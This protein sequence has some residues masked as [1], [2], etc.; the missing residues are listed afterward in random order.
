MNSL[1]DAFIS[2][3]RADSRDFAKY[4]ND[5]L[6]EAGY[7]IWYDFEDI[8]FGVDYQKQI[9]DGIEKADN[10]L[11]IISPHSVNSPYCGLE[12]ELA[13]T[14]NKRIIPLL[15]VEQISRK[16]WQQRN[17]NGTD[18]QWAD[19]QA[20]GKHSSFPNM[21]PEI[22]KINWVYFREGLDDF[23]TSFAGLLELLERHKAYV[24]QHTVL[25]DRALTWERNQ[26]QTRY[27]LI[28]S[29][30]EQA[31]VW[32]ATRFTESQPPCL[33]IDLQC[34]FITE[35]IK[36]ANNLMTQV[37]LCHAEEDR[38]SAEQIRR[39]LLRQG[40]TVWNYRTDIQI[41]QDYHSAIAQGIE[42]ADNVLLMLSPHSTQ[43]AYCQR[44]LEQALAFNKRIIPILAAPIDPE[45][46][47]DNLRSLQ[48]IDLTDN[49]VA[50]D[51]L[52]DESQ[53]LK[54]LNT[55]AAYYTE[56]KT[57]LTQ[58][59]KWQ[60]Q[61]QNPTM[62]LRGY[63]LRRAENWLKVARTHRHLPTELHET[64]IAESLKQPPDPSLDVF[65]SYSRVDSD[66]SRRLNETLQIQGKRTWFDQESIAS[67]TDFQQEI[68][69]GIESSDVFL[70]VL[71][72]QSISSPYCA[73]EVEYAYG[74]NKRIVT[75]LHRPIDT[76]DLHPVLAKLQWIDFR[77]HDGD[78]QVNFQ[79]LLRTL[80]TNREHLET[81]TRLLLR[82][83]EW[84]RRGRDESLLLRGQDLEVA[85]NW[86]ET[87]AEID[88]RP[89]GLQ[90]EYIRAGRARQT[91]QE[92]AEKKLRRGAFIGAVAAAAGVLVAV[93]SG[94]FAW[95]Q[96]QQARASIQDADERIAEADTRVNEANIRVDE[97]KEQ[98]KAANQQTEQ[99]NQQTQQAKQ[100]QQAAVD[101]AQQAAQAQTQAETHA[102]EADGKAQS[103]AA[104]QRQA[105]AKAQ[106]ADEKAQDAEGR[107]R[108]ADVRA[109]EADAKTAAA[110]VAQRLAQTGTRL[111]QAGNAAFNRLRF[112]T[113]GALL[114]ALKAGKELSQIASDVSLT[115]IS[116][117][118]AVSPLLVLQQIK[119]EM[120]GN[121]LF[122]HTESVLSASFGPDG[123]QV[124]TVSRDGTARVWDLASG[125]T[126]VLEG[127][128]S[129]VY[130]T[131]FS[132][133]GTQVVTVSAAGSVRVWDLASG[134]F[135]VLEGHESGVNNASFNH[136]GTQVVTASGDG[137][138]RVWDL[139]SGE[140]QVL[141]GHESWVYS[142]SFNPDGTQVVTA[143]GDGTARVWDL[144]SGETQ[145]L[146]GHESGANNASFSSDGTQVLTVSGD[147][148][149]R[150]WDL[151]SGETQVLEG[152]ETGANNASFNPDGTQVVTA[153]G[154]GTARV[155]DLASGETQ[156][157]EGR[158]SGVNSASFSPDGTQV[159]TVS[160][161][162]SA[163]V[164]DLASGESQVLEG[165]K[166]QV[167]SASFS[168]DGTQVVTA[169]EDGTARVWKVA[170]DTSWV[171]NSLENLS[172]SFSPDGTQIVTV[173]LNET[174]QVWNL[175]TGETQVLEGYEGWVSSASFSPNGIQ[176]VTTLGDGTAQVWDLAS[177]RFQ[178]LEGHESG[179]LITSLSS[180]GSHVVTTLGDGTAQV[181]DL[182]S[183]E[184]QVLKGHEGWVLGISFSPNVTQVV[185]VLEGGT[186]QVW[187][188]ASGETQVLK[189]HEGEVNSV[190]FS[191]DETQVVTVSADGTARV[192]NLASGESQVLEGHKDQVNS[193][194][195]SPDGTQVVTASDDFTVRLWDLKS[196]SFTLL[197]GHADTVRSASF[198]TA[199]D[200]IVTAATDGTMRVWDLRGRQLAI[201]E[202]EAGAL[203]PNGQQVVTVVDGRVQVHDIE[204]L[205]ELIDW[206][207]KWLHN[208]L[209]YGQATDSDRALCNLPPRNSDAANSTPSESS[210]LSRALNQ[211]RKVWRYFG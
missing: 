87:Y 39:S 111:E 123:T 100:A 57:W 21:H 96:Q 8:P 179:V 117:Y 89:T 156:V 60:R 136:N 146:K 16:T 32:L 88:P 59:L 118:P 72:P 137:T 143:S 165:H 37:F 78:F 197:E 181:W 104:A 85:E 112:D 1:Q 98:A 202:G 49:A 203:S 76:V 177:G 46:I 116:D 152:H 83:G 207:C 51:Y 29:D 133:D 86:L 66:F 125:E 155:W 94:W 23:E 149:A 82:A 92:A 69:R 176:V 2:Y 130:S 132:P 13:L 147:G 18:E 106:A 110:E 174:A 93:G 154:D 190:S 74:L 184:T 77:D 50:S 173:L 129:W 191:P 84:D 195:F 79:N 22:G 58:A 135:Q 70:F 189:G 99:A 19:Y 167:N 170:M 148:T 204:T 150:V 211:V 27:L 185:T 171:P 183:G 67:G 182:A 138:A 53:L 41:S 17:S 113:P 164:W 124:V 103:A 35:S 80:D 166:A 178:V 158:E 9:D 153:S 159:V 64:F 188:L 109:L 28:G 193:A 199:G 134:R 25:L 140:T 6:V 7:A 95:T 126:Q 45:Q 127:H 144:A 194:S 90:Q 122:A 208:Y 11:Y 108:T 81:H 210:L 40:V 30:R 151:A 33:P 168:A 56:H 63:N 105:E 200:Q 209:E 48:Q 205:P 162:G 115:K 169:S 128:E 97:A 107:A 3:G 31:Q 62:L 34:E 14:S 180:D 131:N 65:I 186:A 42:A 187:D 160:A 114:N 61:Q 24:H 192:W 26:K 5:R 175:T 12:V 196:G 145:V 121:H 71:S 52:A 141:E 91:A 119:A 36:N 15:H 38:E 75:V 142:A 73:D 163:R 172:I 68:Y 139:A 101:S 120:D 55:D 198:N 44:E 102:Q 47:P 54:I 43:S 161:A 201:Y 157:L 20:T 4:L 206:G 10:F